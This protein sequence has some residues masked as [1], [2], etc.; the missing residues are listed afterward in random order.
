MKTIMK[1]CILVVMVLITN[2]NYV[3]ATQDRVMV[4]NKFRKIASGITQIDSGESNIIFKKNQN[5]YVIGS[6]RFGCLGYGEDRIKEEIIL[7]PNQ[8][9]KNVKKI[10]C[11]KDVVAFTKKKY[12]YFCGTADNGEFYETTG[13]Y[14]ELTPFTPLNY[15]QKL[16]RIWLANGNLLYEQKNSLYINGFLVNPIDQSSYNKP[17]CILKNK[18]NTVKSIALSS[19][20]VVIHYKNGGADI[21]GDDEYNRCIRNRKDYQHYDKFVPLQQF[22]SGIK[23]YVAGE[24]NVGAIKK[25]GDFYIWGSNKHG[26]LCDKSSKKVSNKPKLV[27][28]NVK[29]VS[30]KYNHV[31]ALK[32][33]GTVWAW[34]RNHQKAIN[35][36]KN[37]VIAKP[38]K[39]A[40][41][42]KKISTGNGFSVI[43]KNNK[44]AYWK[45]TL[46]WTPWLPNSPKW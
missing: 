34:G 31:L 15:N 37:K 19:N 11:S 35:Q 45:G 27:L 44:M 42:V 21:M 10:Y 17:K 18:L 20:Y 24:K 39:I 1:F 2:L 3:Q 23:K 32:R 43:L 36:S 7:Q 8:I 9:G 26:F 46:S 28:K 25:N 12:I 40:S 30:M 5:A 29:D 22:R 38:T 4:S 14:Y 41:N 16:R 33:N 13:D 6:D